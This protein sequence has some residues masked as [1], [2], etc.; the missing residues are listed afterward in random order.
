DRSSVLG[1]IGFSLCHSVDCSYACA[2]FKIVSSPNGLPSN[3]KPIGN[4]GAFVN[5]HGKLNP[6][7]PAK[8][9]EIVKMSD[10]YICNGS[11]DFSPALKAAVGVVGV[12]IAST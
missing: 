1:R 5:P 2:S 4:L 10:K 8:L 3:C 6:Q 9:H 7:I 11:S 12:T